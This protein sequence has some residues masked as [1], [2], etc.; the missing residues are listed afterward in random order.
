MF[1]L[2]NKKEEETIQEI[3]Q[4]VNNPT[5][6]QETEEQS[7]MVEVPIFLSEMDYKRMTY[8]NWVMNKKILDLLTDLISAI[9]DELKK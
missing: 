5:T 8:E 3:K 2:K 9:S 7:S 1:K 6:P 4:A